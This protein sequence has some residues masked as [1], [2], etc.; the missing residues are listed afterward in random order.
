LTVVGCIDDQSNVVGCGD[1]WWLYGSSINRRSWLSRPDR[2]WC[3]AVG[4]DWF[5]VFSSE[6]RLILVF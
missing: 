2:P 5:L 6:I 1:C 3:F 4:S